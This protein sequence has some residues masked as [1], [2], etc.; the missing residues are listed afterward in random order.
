MHCR[1]WKKVLN[2]LDML[3]SRIFSS[4]SCHSPKEKRLI[5]FIGKV[6]TVYLFHYSCGKPRTN[7]ARARGKD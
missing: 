5:Y 4:L 2:Q 6:Q 7:L 3:L 1:L